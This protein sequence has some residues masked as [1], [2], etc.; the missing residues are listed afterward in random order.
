MNIPSCSAILGMVVLFGFSVAP[1]AWTADVAPPKESGNTAATTAPAGDTALAELRMKREKAQAELNAVNQPTTLAAGAPPGT[2]RE[3]LLE[4]STLLHHIVRSL[5]EQID[6]TLR[7]EQARR[8]RKK[9]AEASAAT[10]ENVETEAPPYSV[11]FA[12]QLW[13]TAFSLRLAA[14]GLQSQLNLIEL[15]SDHARES[16]LAAEERLRQASEQLESMKGTGSADRQRW[17]RD[18]EALR[19]RAAAAQLQAAVLSKT[20]TEEE[21]ADA[22]ARLESAE[23]R[24]A[25][26]EP[27]V[28]FTE[29]D[30][31]KIRT[32]LSE[33]RTHLTD[34]LEQ[35]TADRLRQFDEL[36][37][38]EGQLAAHLSKGGARGGQTSRTIRRAQA[39]VDV[40]RM[41]TDNLSAKSDLLQ[42]L[43]DVVEGERQ[44]WESRFAIVHDREPGKIREAYDRFTPL[45]TNF[46]ASRDYVRQQL[47]IVSGQIGERESRLKNGAL[48][49]AAGRPSGTGGDVQ[50]DAP[51][52]GPGVPVSRPLEID[53]QGA[54]TR[55][56]SLRATGRMV[57]ALVGQ[58]QSRMGMGG[59]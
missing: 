41:R 17:I 20:R 50:P 52:P 33:E 10:Q 25:A 12:D 23:H 35:T 11:F 45:F 6:D 18:L 40:A 46:Q 2:P 1:E 53:V 5:D 16:L 30:L 36:R 9:L 4:R 22:R 21:L 47:S 14:E 57:A 39:A 29:D 48:E 3:E 51:A 32:R 8:H 37:A 7:V 42:L 56:S 26:V 54:T 55:T 24:L 49:I 44:L 19:Q 27:Q 34:E 13:D 31:A 59:L 43:L 38:L 15:R 28:R 58:N